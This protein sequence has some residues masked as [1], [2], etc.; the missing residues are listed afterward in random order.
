MI[1]SIMDLSTSLYR[2]LE[3]QLGY[4][5]LITE[6]AV[7][8]AVFLLH[9]ASLFESIFKTM[10]ISAIDVRTSIFV[11]SWS[12]CELFDISTEFLSITEFVDDAKL[13]KQ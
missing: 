4:I 10:I 8:V 5:D 2:R 6:R 9:F 1:E 7:A 13:I 3:L 12:S 11:F